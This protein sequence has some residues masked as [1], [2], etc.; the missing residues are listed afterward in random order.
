MKCGFLERNDGKILL[1]ELARRILRPTSTEDEIKGY[2][3]AV[4]QA[5]EVSDVYK[6]YRGDTFPERFLGIQL[7]T[8]IH[9]PESDTFGVPIIMPS[10]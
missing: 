5:L 6:H 8:H 7:L 3:E 2:R 9:I 1:T 10:L 4:L